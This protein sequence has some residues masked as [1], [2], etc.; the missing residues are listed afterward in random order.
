MEQMWVKMVLPN[1]ARHVKV[2]VVVKHPQMLT[3]VD[4]YSHEDDDFLV[5][6]AFWLGKIGSILIFKKSKINYG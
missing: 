1:K 4:Q 5:E 3:A 2:V 6:K